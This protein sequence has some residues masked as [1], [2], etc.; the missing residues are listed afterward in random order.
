[1]PLAELTAAATSIK[2]VLDIAKGLKQTID[3][4]KLKEEIS[5]LLD[6]IIDLQSH[7]LIIN[8]DYQSILEE[9]YKLRQEI[10]NFKNWD[11][12]KNK[13]K[14]LSIDGEVFV[15]VPKKSQ[16]AGEP[17]YQLCANCFQHN[18]RKSILQVKGMVGMNRLTHYCTF[19][20]NEYQYNLNAIP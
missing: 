3:D 19:C 15:Y 8:T 11:N 13:Y 2:A 4:V 20:K 14:L 1:M 6:S 10:M 7:I 17:K 16:K 18:N 12:E 5:P 9:N